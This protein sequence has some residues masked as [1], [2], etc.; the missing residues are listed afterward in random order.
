MDYHVEL[1]NGKKALVISSENCLNI[2]DRSCFPEVFRLL[3][4][5]DPDFVVLAN[6]YRKIYSEEEIKMLKEVGE[7]IKKIKTKPLQIMLCNKC[8]QF[9]EKYKM[10]SEVEK[11]PLY[12]YFTAVEELMNPSVCGSCFSRAKQL[13][14]LIASALERTELVKRAVKIGGGRKAYFEIFNP[15]VMPGFLTSFIDF[16][17]PAKGKL[18]EEYLVKD[19]VVRIYEVPWRPEKY[20]Y[21][22]APEFLLHEDEVKAVA[23]ALDVISREESRIVDPKKAR[24]YFKKIAEEVLLK[25]GSSSDKLSEVIARHSAGYGLLEILLQDKRL[26][27]IYV[28]SPGGNYVYVYHEDHEECITNITLTSFDLEKLS[29][30]FRAISGR[31]FDESSPVLHAELPELGVR[32]CGVCFPA[33]FD[34]IGFAFRRHKST[35]WT[36]PQFIK[37]GMLDHEVAGLLSFLVDGQRSILVT[38]ARSSGKT[39]LL[40]SLLTETPRNYRVVVIEDTPELPVEKL[41]QVGYKIQHLRTEASLGEELKKGFEL[42]ATEALRTALRLGES[43]LVIGEVRGPEARALFEAMRIGAA[44]NVVMGTIHG[45]S[46]YDTWDRI[47]NDLGVPSTSFKATDIVV[48][49]AALRKGDELRRYRKLTEVTEVRKHWKE[50]PVHEQGFRN[51]VEYD[52]KK[53]SWK[54]NIEESEAV[55]QAARLKNMSLKEAAENIKYRGLIKKE[56]VECSESLKKPELLEIAVSYTHLTLPTN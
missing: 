9:E 7:T 15:Y 35:P 26:Q 1:V 23:E 22:E 18:I 53:D 52:E 25:H 39:S 36:L 2:F 56:L 10:I 40:T 33:T 19:S 47:V 46:A 49:L 11:D 42:T 8:K 17:K 29:A 16:K 28:D 48:S 13:L 4:D 12:S 43:V 45:S 41:K 14:E 51:L 54:L 30:R 37:A 3:N 32:V 5:E 38:G 50:D 24:E 20:Y 55:K 34:G 27:D 21:V 6:A 44:G 31:P